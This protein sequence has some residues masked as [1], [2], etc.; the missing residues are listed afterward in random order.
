M[1][2]S[3]L[4]GMCV[5]IREGISKKKNTCF[6]LYDSI[7]IHSLLACILLVHGYQLLLV[8]I[9]GLCPISR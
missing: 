9:D 8:I 3:E 1:Y 4:D 7:L 5:A 6:Q 2:H